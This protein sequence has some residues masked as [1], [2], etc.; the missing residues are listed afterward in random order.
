MAE[1][2]VWI[3]MKI[4]SADNVVDA[5]EQ[6]HFIIQE[7]GT[8]W[9]CRVINCRTKKEVTIDLDGYGEES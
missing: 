3:G 5:A 8:N 4:D 2:D 1:Y 9:L 6:A 7:P